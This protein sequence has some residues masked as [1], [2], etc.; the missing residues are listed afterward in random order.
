MASRHFISVQ[1]AHKLI[2]EN[3]RR[4][5]TVNRDLSHSCGYVLS[6]N[7][8]SPLHA[9]PFDQSA[10]D[11]FAIRFA[12]HTSGNPMILAGT[13]KA[14]SAFHGIMKNGEAIRIFTGACLPRGADTVVIQE[15]TSL[16][17]NRLFIADDLLRK[18]ANIRKAGSQVRSGAIAMKSGMVL[19]SGSIG[20][21]AS[22]GIKRVQVSRKPVT[23]IIVTGD[24]L[25][26][27]G[28]ALRPG[29]IYESN[30]MMLRTLLAV[31]GIDDPVILFVKD[32]FADVRN[33]FRRMMKTCDL[34]LVSGG[35]SV[36]DYDFTGRVVEEAGVREVFYKVKQKP[37]KPLYFGVSDNRYVFGLPGN[38]A[39]VL[40]CYYEYVLPAIRLFQGHPRPFLPVFRLPVKQDVRKKPGLTVFLK[41][42]ASATGVELLGG[43]ESYIL[44][45]FSE[46][47]AFII[48]DESGGGCE[49]GSEVDVHLFGEPSSN[50]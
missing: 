4:G 42:R 11:G 46:A 13:V 48:M 27:P 47:N 32:R 49:A 17:D 8:R 23:G 34:I 10:M 12:D 31:E 24:E 50:S 40:T 20:F 45:S 25:V 18:G 21:L 30:S 29:T 43:Q 1:Q 39:S 19:N 6:E 3:V 15:R 41:A 44:Q 7:I 16:R 38:P 36:G 33:A 2:V 22:L 9:P 26:Q 14:G 37:G 35:I 5:K 28:K